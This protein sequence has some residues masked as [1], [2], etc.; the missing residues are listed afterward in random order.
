MHERNRWDEGVKWCFT[1]RKRVQFWQ[2]LRTPS[3]EDLIATMG[4]YDHS[5][6]VECEK[7]HMDGDM[8]PGTS[9]E[10]DE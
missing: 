3:M 7:G 10:W 1:C 6:T 8:F 4:F 2:I 9:R 5:R